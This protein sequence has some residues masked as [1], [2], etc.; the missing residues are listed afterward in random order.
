MELSPLLAPFAIPTSFEPPFVFVGI[1]SAIFGA[2]HLT[3]RLG[4]HTIEPS[5]WTSLR[6]FELIVLPVMGILLLV[7]GERFWFGLSTIYWWVS[8]KCEPPVPVAR[9]DGRTE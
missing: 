9:R 4:H 1:L 7:V 2:S 8:I 6:L 3:R 5:L